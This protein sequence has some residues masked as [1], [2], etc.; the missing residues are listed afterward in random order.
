MKIG[1]YE[2]KKLVAQ[3]INEGFADELKELQHEHPREADALSKT[4]F[5]DPRGQPT[6]WFKWLLP[7]FLTGRIKEDFAF[8][9][10]V[11]TVQRYAQKEQALNVAFRQPAF[12]EA[13]VAALPTNFNLN[14]INDPSQLNVREMDSI[15]EVLS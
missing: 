11:D 2:L 4:P 13:V 1:L 10:V 14:K 5:F 3:I 7:R 9:H 12:K 8:D 15:L 6:K